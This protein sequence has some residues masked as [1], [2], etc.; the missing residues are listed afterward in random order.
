MKKTWEGLSCKIS[1]KQKN[2]LHTL[3]ICSGLSMSEHVRRAIDAYIDL[4]LIRMQEDG[5]YMGT[6]AD[7]A[8]VVKNK[9]TV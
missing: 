4:H 8:Y 2:D 3:L 1:Q 9:G 6:G 5:S 7:E